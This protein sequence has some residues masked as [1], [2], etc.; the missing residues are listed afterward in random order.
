MKQIE[1]LEFNYRLRAAGG[2]IMLFPDIRAQYYPSSTT[3]SSFFLHNLDDG[4]WATYPLKYGFRVSLRHIIPLLFVLT[5]F[6]SF[7]LYIWVS[8]IFSIQVAAEQKDW[9]LAF[10]MPLAFGARHIGY[11]VGSIIG[12][13]KIIFKI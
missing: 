8:L 2:K 3:L 11:G 1:D 7:W 12:L 6:I 9:R 13:F 10:V 5:I 4:I